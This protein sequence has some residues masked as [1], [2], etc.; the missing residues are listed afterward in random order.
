MEKLINKELII[1][2]EKE[3][4]KSNH[5]KYHKYFKEWLSNITLEQIDGF[6]RMMFGQNNQ[7][8]IIH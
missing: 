4:Y 8:K 3:F 5:P 7:T 1:W 6:N 2:L